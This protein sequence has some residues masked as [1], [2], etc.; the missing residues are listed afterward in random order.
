MIRTGGATM[1]ARFTPQQAMDRG[2][3]TPA[4]CDLT[5]ILLWG[6]MGTPLTEMKADGTSYLS[7][8]EWEF[9][10]ALAANKPVFVYRRVR[11]SAL[12][13]RRRRTSTR[14]SSR[15]GAWT[16]SSSGSG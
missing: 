15:N 13:R 10:N 5:V 12:G 1:D 14:S 9:E 11:E 2:L 7:G 6:R 16:P 8:T 4:D 3:P